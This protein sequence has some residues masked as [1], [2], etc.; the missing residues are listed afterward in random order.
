MS[1]LVLEIIDLLTIV[2]KNV[3][4][5]IEQCRPSFILDRLLLTCTS[6]NIEVYL[7]E[8]KVM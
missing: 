8:Y 7:V 2:I 5:I 3:L 4:S 6:N 1:F